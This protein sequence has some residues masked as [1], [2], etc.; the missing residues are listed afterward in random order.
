MVRQ[1]FGEKSG[2]VTDI[3]RKLGTVTDIWSK[4]G[5]VTDKE[6]EKTVGIRCDRQRDGEIYENLVF[7]YRGTQLCVDST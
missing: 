6:K 7:H 1:T 2:G 4:L 3:W 5:G